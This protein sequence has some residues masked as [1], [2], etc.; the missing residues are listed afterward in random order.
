MTVAVTEASGFAS[1]WLPFQTA[2]RRVTNVKKPA[3]MFALSNWKQIAVIPAVIRALHQFRN[4]FCF[5]SHV[6][7][8]H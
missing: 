3:K 7:L 2:K 4:C 1:K 6:G 8:V 5:S